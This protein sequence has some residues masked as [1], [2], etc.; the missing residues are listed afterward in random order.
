MNK[1]VIAIMLVLSVLMVSCQS[2]KDTT[3]DNR[4]SLSDKTLT[5]IGATTEEMPIWIDHIERFNEGSD[6][7]YAS[8]V[9]SLSD[10]YYAMSEAKTRAKADLASYIEDSVKRRIEDAGGSTGSQFSETIQ[11]AVDQS[12]HLAETVERFTDST[13]RTYVLMRMPKDYVTSK[14]DSMVDAFNT[15]TASE[16]AA[17]EALVPAP[18]TPAPVTQAPVTQAPV[19]QDSPT[20]SL[21]DLLANLKK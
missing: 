17:A 4:P 2:T 13:G 21:A 12:I 5:T 9:S 20:Y 1:V 6:Y 3:N 14:V 19:T 15:K 7:Y 16:A 10:P 11:I 8:G 18:V